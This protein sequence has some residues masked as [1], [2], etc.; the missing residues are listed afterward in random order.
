[1]VEPERRNRYHLDVLMAATNNLPFF[2]ELA[3]N[4]RYNEQQIHEKLCRRLI[5]VSGNKGSA[6]IKRSR[7]ILQ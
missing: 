7:Q 4:L 5:H 2:K 3:E 6:I 1:M